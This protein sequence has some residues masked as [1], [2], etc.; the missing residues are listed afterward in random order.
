MN[1][2]QS[3]YCDRILRVDLTRG[4]ITTEPLPEKAIPLV[5]GGKGFGAY[6]LLN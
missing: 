1:L 6:L 2:K 3:G 4:A 5:V